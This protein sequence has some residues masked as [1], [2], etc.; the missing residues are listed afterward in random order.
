MFKL[1]KY[2]SDWG[3]KVNLTK[4]N[5]VVFNKS[6]NNSIKL[7]NFTF[8]GNPIKTTKSYC[9][10]GIDITSTGSFS[11][12]L[13]SLYKKSL[14]A[15][16]SVFATVNVYSDGK[17]IPLFLKLFD[18]LIKPILLYGCEIWGPSAFNNNNNP[19]VKFVNKFYRTLL[20]VPKHSST[21]GIHV[22]LGRFPLSL[23]IKHAMLKYWSRLVTLP[24]SRL[25][26]HCYWSLK[27]QKNS[28]DLWLSSIKQIIESA[29]QR[30]FN[31]L[32]NSQNSLHKV[33]PKITSKCHSQILKTSKISFLSGAVN[34][35]DGQTKLQFFK[36]GKTEFKIS[37]FLDAIDARNARSLLCKLR[38]GV[39]DLE[40]ESGRRFKIDD[41]GKKTKIDRS[42]RFCKLCTTG[43]IEDEPHFLF[44][45]PALHQTRHTF[46]SPL[47]NICE[48]LATVS[49]QDKLMYL[50]F[51]ENI[52]AREL[53]LATTLLTK[54][55]AARD[56]L[57]SQ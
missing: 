4:T 22:E 41:T 55:K 24:D 53:S 43:E 25:V 51:N 50:Y 2:C 32:W 39:L 8:D 19:L 34:D 37:N 7:L 40:I 46:L 47:F 42:E 54:L 9:Y 36:E 30:N 16:Y 17:S 45:C 57:L 23:Y 15:L 6:F 14:R 33:D 38:L 35:M 12:A 13:D 26:S 20:G 28:K 49:H 44:A 10:L 29:G 31:F 56:I 18:A 11:A 27:K 5:V 3:L 21:V 52:D 48:E 1:E